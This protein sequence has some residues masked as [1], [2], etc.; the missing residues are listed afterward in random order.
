M[1]NDSKQERFHMEK[2]NK[3]RQRRSIDGGGKE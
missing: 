3:W 2:D 1:T